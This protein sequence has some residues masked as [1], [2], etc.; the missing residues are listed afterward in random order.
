MASVRGVS[1]LYVRGRRIWCRL[2]NERGKWVA[3]KTPYFAGDDELAERY[4]KTA[5][6]AYDHKRPIAAS[7]PPTVEQFAEKW[8]ADREVGTNLSVRDDAGRIRN[9]VLKHIGSALM[10]N[11]KPR[12]IRDMVR[13]L[14]RNPDIAPRTIRNI[15]GIT[16]AMFKDAKIDEVIDSNPCELKRDDLPA[17]V[18]KDPEWRNA[19]TYT[20]EEIRTL[21]SDPRIPHV[22][23]VQY[24]LK[25]LAGLRHG[26]VAGL[27]WRHHDTAPEPLGRLLVA[28]SYDTGRTKTEVTRRVPIHPE[29]ARIMLVWR[30]AWPGIYGHE[31]RP[32]DRIVATKDGAVISANL[33][34]SYMADDMDKVGMPKPAGEHRNR[35]GHD[36][37]A[38]FIT[39]CQ[40]A[41]AHRELLRVVTHTSKGDVMSGYTRATWAALCGEVSK[42]RV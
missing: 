8:L 35:G 21:I 34:G 13:S 1:S 5:Q 28:S 16:H 39:S 22:R 19:A 38:W 30:Q 31:P 7:G 6:K 32:D 14:R 11:V 36:M 33:A 40:E 41:G 3:E 18:D 24:A 42:L 20:V 23:R 27:R 17:K 2:K 37:R 4:A 25:A 15:Y 12:D 29:L 9:H 26:E 10:P